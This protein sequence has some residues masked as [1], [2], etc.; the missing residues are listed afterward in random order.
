M[1]D[2]IATVRLTN[3][4]DADAVA[5]RVG[6]WS[7][8]ADWPHYLLPGLA[9]DMG[10]LCPG[11]VLGAWCEIVDRQLVVGVQLDSW[12]DGDLLESEFVLRA[13]ICRTWQVG[14]DEVDVEYEC[15]CEYECS[16]A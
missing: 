14:D 11:R 6:T 13:Y 16:C 8:V 5:E 10:A 1:A 12:F 7:V 15:A 3:P 2:M 4:Y 9:R